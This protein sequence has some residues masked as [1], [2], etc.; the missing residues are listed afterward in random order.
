MLINLTGHMEYRALTVNDPAVLL[1]PAED[2]L[3]RKIHDVLPSALMDAF[4]RCVHRVHTTK[5]AC[6][7]MYPVKDVTYRG[8][9]TAPGRDT[10][11]VSVARVV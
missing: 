10:L 8:T 4:D 2:R 9:I 7:Y 5:R 11:I 3:G 1:A 6:T